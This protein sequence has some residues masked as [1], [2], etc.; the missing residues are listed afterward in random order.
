MSYESELPLQAEIIDTTNTVLGGMVH[1]IC[2][3]GYD[4]LVTAPIP[5]PND[6]PEIPA[7]RRALET[8]TISGFGAVARR[9][10]LRED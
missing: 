5:G 7:H 9:T 8:R 6:I 10:G 3:S 2:G 4:S 1:E